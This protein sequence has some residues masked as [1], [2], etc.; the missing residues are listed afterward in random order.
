[1]E[2]LNEF[3]KKFVSDWLDGFYKVYDTNNLSEEQIVA[4]FIDTVLSE[5]KCL[6][7]THRKYVIIDEE[8]GEESID[9]SRIKTLGNLEECLES[10]EEQ[11]LYIFEKD[12]VVAILGHSHGEDFWSWNYK[13]EIGEQ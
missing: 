4:D 1:M 3:L 10:D 7:F 12:N 8:T 9:K 5:Q 11:G 13:T 2:I 6:S